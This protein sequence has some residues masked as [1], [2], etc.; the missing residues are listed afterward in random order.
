MKLGILTDIHEDILSLEK[1]LCLL[2][3][4]GCDQLACLG[5]IIGFCEPNIPHVKKRD[6]DACLRLIRE[7]CTFVVAGNHDLNAANRIPSMSGDFNYPSYWHSLSL[8]EKQTI[9]AGKVWVYEDELPTLMNDISLEYLDSL[10]EYCIIENEHSGILLSHFIFPDISG[11]CTAFPMQRRDTTPHFIFM[12]EQQCNLSVFGHVH[13]VGML[14][15]EKSV[16]LFS[17]MR[18]P[19]DFLPLGEY[20]LGKKIAAIA[21]PAVVKSERKSGVGILDTVCK[22]ISAIQLY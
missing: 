13:P 8:S 22:T 18:E 21:M 6:A 16:R 11:A 12:H 20:K 17:Y 14:R 2:E 3:K 7:N 15:T 9:A 19:F 1:A 5:D 4:E 10:P